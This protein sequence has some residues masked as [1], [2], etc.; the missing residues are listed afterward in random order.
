MGGHG[1]FLPRPLR[2]DG[3]QILPV[4][5]GACFR[6]THAGENIL[7]HDNPAA[8]ASHMKPVS[9]GGER[10]VALAQ[11]TKHP[12]AYRSEIIPAICTSLPGDL[13][14]AVLEMNMP[15]ALTETV[16]PVLDVPAIIAA[17]PLEV[18]AGI[19]HQPQQV[20]IGHIQETQRSSRPFDIPGTTGMK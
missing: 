7:L 11:F 14:L 12:V 5:L 19:E 9:D 18:G 13:R 2:P 16:Q 3:S 4:T 1:I 20:R 6:A 17:G 8:I 10:H 15:D